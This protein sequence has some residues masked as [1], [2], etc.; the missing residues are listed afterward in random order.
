MSET[1]KVDAAGNQSEEKVEIHNWVEYYKPGNMQKILGNTWKAFTPVVFIYYIMQFCMAVAACNF[2]SD[3]TRLGA[4][5][6]ENG[7]VKTGEDASAVMDTAIKLCGVFHIIEWI[8]TTMLLCV[9]LIGSPLLGVWYVSGISS[10][11]GI[12]AF[13]YMHAVAFGQDAKDCADSQTTRYEWLKY[14][15]IYFWV[16][17][18][19]FQLPMGVFRFFKKEQLSKWMVEEEE[20]EEE[21]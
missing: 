13:I 11:F 16:F 7:V 4:C 20:D 2:Y 5:N 17:F 10:L 21:D 3:V 1:A 8:R 12:V 19:V 14:E 9:V 15:I 18:W 6:M